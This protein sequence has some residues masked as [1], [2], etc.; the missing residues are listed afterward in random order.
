MTVLG[1]PYM[2]TKM[3]QLVSAFTL[4]IPHGVK[5]KLDHL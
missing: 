4:D 3:S 2:S 1:M 5:H